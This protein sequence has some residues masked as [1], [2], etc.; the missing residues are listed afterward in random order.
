MKPADYKLEE[1]KWKYTLMTTIL[2]LIVTN[3]AMYRLTHKLV[4]KVVKISNRSGC[5]TLA[6]YLIHAVVFT[7]ILRWMMN[8]DK[9]H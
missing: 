2:F 3:P 7:F 9:D 1:R 6:G 5:P 4:G 8:I